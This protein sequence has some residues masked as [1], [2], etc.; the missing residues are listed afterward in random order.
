MRK[1]LNRFLAAAARRNLRV[2]IAEPT[3]FDRRTAEKELRQRNLVLGD[4]FFSLLELA[5]GLRL[6]DDGQHELFL[7]GRW[8]LLSFAEMLLAYDADYIAE[9][10]YYDADRIP[11]REDVRNYFQIC[12]DGFGGGLYYGD[13][14]R[15]G[16]SIFECSTG[17]TPC[18]IYCNFGIAFD[19]FSYTLEQLPSFGERRSVDK[20]ED[21]LFVRHCQ[22]RNPKMEYWQVA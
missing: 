2:V 15:C 16:L 21:Q 5:N 3:G 18:G 13:I 20:E 8:S 19:C 4:E 10:E 17:N 12:H 14:D 7:G 9:T 6:F 22:R 1:A 11:P